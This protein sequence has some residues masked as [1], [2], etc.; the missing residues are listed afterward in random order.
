MAHLLLVFLA[1]AVGSGVDRDVQETGLHSRQHTFTRGLMVSVGWR[2]WGVLKGRWRAA[3]VVGSSTGKTFPSSCSLQGFFPRARNLMWAF[4]FFQ[5]DL[6]YGP[7]F[8][9]W[10]AMVL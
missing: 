1:A 5:R 10:F 9:R 3:F 4:T 6:N 2:N 7:L 8:C